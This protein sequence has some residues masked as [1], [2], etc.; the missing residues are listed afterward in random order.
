MT[1]N[2][3]NSKIKSGAID[4]VIVACP[5]VFGR[6]VGK[7]F[8][9][10]FFLDHVVKS[11]THG[12]NYLLTVNMEMDPMDG[13]KLANWDKGFGDFEMRPDLSTLRALP[14]QAGAALVLCDYVHDAGKWVEETPRS[15]LRRQVDLLAKKKLTAY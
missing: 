1:S 6:L 14:W 8:T 2:Q 11:S 9:G 3:L 10:P 12:C 4:T 7:R 5:D 15:V 13:F